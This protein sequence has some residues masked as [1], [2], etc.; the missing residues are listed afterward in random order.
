MSH[1]LVTYTVKAGH[2]QE[3]AALVRAVSWVS[4]PLGLRLDTG[5][6]RPDQR[7]DKVPEDGWVRSP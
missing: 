6:D 5:S 2:E 1:T 3:N 4:Y 7:A